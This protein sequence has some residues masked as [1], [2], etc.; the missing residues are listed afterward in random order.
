MDVG[1]LLGVLHSPQNIF[2]QLLH[3][4][5]GPC[6]SHTPV[7]L[8]HSPPCP[9]RLGC[10]CGCVMAIVFQNERANDDKQRIETMDRG[11]AK[12]AWS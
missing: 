7:L 12:L 2:L 11:N 6:E 1:L 9:P 8:E 3:R 4:P 5:G 10:A